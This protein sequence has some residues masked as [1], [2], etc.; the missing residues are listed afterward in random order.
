MSLGCEWRKIPS[1]HHYGQGL[2]GG[3]VLVACAVEVG[4][5]GCKRGQVESQTVVQLCCSGLCAVC[6]TGIGGRLEQEMM[7]GFLD[8]EVMMWA[9]CKG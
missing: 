6:V 4:K 7:C 1:L 5:L 2:D 3:H 8:W 9:S